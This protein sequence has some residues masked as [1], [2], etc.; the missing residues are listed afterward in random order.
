MEEENLA[1]IR[2][3]KITKMGVGQHSKGI[4]AGVK[5]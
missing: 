3:D 4:D 1:I 2:N 5:S